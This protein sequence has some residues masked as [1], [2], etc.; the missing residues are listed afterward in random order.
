[1]NQTFASYSYFLK[2]IFLV[3][4]L[5]FAFTLVKRFGIAVFLFLPLLLLLLLLHLISGLFFRQKYNGI[6]LDY[7]RA[8]SIF[9]PK[10]I[11]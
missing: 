6:C 11:T 3:S 9:Y 7:R 8:P 1:M 5:V 2:S 10:Q 4:D